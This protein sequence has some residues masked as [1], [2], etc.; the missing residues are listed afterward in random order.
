LVSRP[1]DRK[2]VGTWFMN[3]LYAITC[4]IIYIQ[5]MTRSKK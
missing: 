4:Y 1:L 2:W 3:H 5:W